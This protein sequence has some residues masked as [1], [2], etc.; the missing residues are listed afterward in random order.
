[1]V[2]K[3]SNFI[4]KHNFPWVTIETPW[5]LHDLEEPSFLTISL[6]MEIK[7]KLNLYS[8][9]VD[10]PAGAYPQHEATRSKTK[11]NPQTEHNIRW[12]RGS[13]L[14]KN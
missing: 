2:K 1:M 5:L 12:Q 9:Q 13:R 10:Y 14:T 6:L 3:K 4:E 11:V 8:S 7:I